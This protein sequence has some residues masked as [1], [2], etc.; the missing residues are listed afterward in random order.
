MFDF[1]RRHT[2]VLQFVLVLLVFPSFV[3]FGIQ[4]YSRFSGGDQQT[5]AKVAGTGITQIE[6][7]N[8][9]RDRIERARRQMPTLD[10]K[11][12]DTPEMR[13]LA[14]DSIIRDR[15]LSAA[16]DKLHLVTTD[17]RLDSLFKS[18]PQF[19]QLRRPDGSVNA[20][21][22]AAVGMSSE[23]FA[24]RLREDIS[25]RQVLQSL[26]DSSIAPAAAASAALDAMYQ[27]RE[28]Q[29][30]RF[31]AKDYAAQ[32]APTDAQIDAFYKDPAHAAQFQAPEQAS[33][34][35]VTLDLDG[36][37][38]G[39]TVSD[40]DL[41]KYYTENV[42]RYTTTEE[43]HVRQIL[44]AAA[45][46]A[47]K[48]ERDKARAKAE[49][50]TAEARKDPKSFAALA[51]KNSDDDST[52][53]KGGD[54]EFFARGSMLDLKPFEDA[55]FQLKP[56]EIAGP[57]ETDFG[58]H[59]IQLVE[60]RGGETKPFDAV[61]ADME[62]EIRNQLAQKKFS[63]AAVEFGDTVYE[64][65]DSLK[66]AADKWK[67]D[68]RKA[69]HVTPVPAAGAASGPLGSA[70]FL[71]AVFSN[72]A[73]RNKHNTKAIDI[74]S[75]QLVSGRVLQYTPSHMQPLADVQDKIRAELVAAQSAALAEKLGAER[76]AAVRAA[77]ATTLSDN[78]LVV[79]RAQPHDLPR[80]V[81][82][83]VLKAPVATLP[84]FVGVDLGNQGYV[85]AK[86][87]KL[88]GRDPSVAD[89]AK[90]RDQY[91]RIW[92]DAESQAYYEALKARYKVS[93]SDNL[94]PSAD[95]A[96]ATAR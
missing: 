46:D 23:T 38:K 67:L 60:T 52:A 95:S 87:T 61:K 96:S 93:V 36:L 70:K 20:D 55:A 3:F 68:I 40:D 9:I 8:V 63:D 28:V 10:A 34:E 92:G 30:Q 71:E 17:E 13:R 12:F 91:A 24:E 75:N 84:A 16:A 6:L 27:Q 74:G 37:K 15:V 44:V 41:H 65:S 59:V 47:P 33:I 90:A 32:V 79:S 88:W 89:P 49:A 31:E 43:R 53:K 73:T 21:A 69:D 82:D 83:A 48:A 62:S 35:Y 1:F 14:L 51:E 11:M 18:D 2:R 45:K 19:A 58:Y 66:P 85:V 86:I 57:V 72:D 78:T 81:L 42:K 22:L 94:S 56:G 76:L 4:G 5:V 64:Q 50:L 29:V 77:P 25:R 54:M 26:A 80:S 39:V 7:D